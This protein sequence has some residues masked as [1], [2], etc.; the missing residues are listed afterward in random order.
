MSSLLA[1]LVLVAVWVFVL[2][3]RFE[4]RRIMTAG[5]AF[6]MPAPSTGLFLQEGAA[7]LAFANG[8][9]AVQRWRVDR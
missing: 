1:R 4:G 8:S 5:D 2:S 9:R 7:T 3:Q 6:G